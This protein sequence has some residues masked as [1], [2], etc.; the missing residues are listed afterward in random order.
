MI[1]SRRESVSHR[2]LGYHLL[3]VVVVFVVLQRASL[4][5]QEPPGDSIE[6]WTEDQVQE[7]LGRPSMWDRQPDGTVVWYYDGT[8]KGTLRVYFVNGRVVDMRRH[9]LVRELRLKE[10]ARRNIADEQAFVI[11][12]DD[13]DPSGTA[14]WYYDGTSQGTVRVY[15]TNGQAERAMPEHGLRELWLKDLVRRNEVSAETRH[16]PTAEDDQ[17]F[18]PGPSLQNPR[19]LREVKPRYTAE[20]MRAKVQGSV[21]LE[22][23]VLSDGM[24]GDITVTKSLDTVFGLDEEA[25]RAAQQWRFA[26]GTRFGEPVS[27]LVSIEMSFSTKK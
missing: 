22:V 25:I 1:A 23:V 9:G 13:R 4:P 17:V 20:A 27:V 18:K 14:V 10:L 24:V 12:S 15:F 26:P 8:S 11:S 7:A 16:S 6:G 21:W 5:A 19:I 3:F 2:H